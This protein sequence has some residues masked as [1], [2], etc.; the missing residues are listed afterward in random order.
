M[1]GGTTADAAGSDASTSGDAGLGSSLVFP[2]I[3]SYFIETYVGPEHEETMARADVVVI[4]V[5]ATALS[6]DALKRVRT[7]NPKADLLAYLTSEEIPHAID[8]AERPFAAERFAKIAPSEW[9]VDPGSTTTAALNATA[10]R[11]KV[12]S[13]AAFSVTRPESDFYEEDEPTY[14]LV[15]GEHMRLVEVDGNELVVERGYR[16][17]AVAH[18]TGSKIAS[19]VVFFAGTWMLNL[20]ATAPKGPA[21]TTW[22]DRLVDDA[23]GLVDKGP[24]TGVFLDVCFEDI[25]WLNGGLLDVNRDGVADD[26]KEASKQWSLGMGLAVDAAR[27]RLGPSV[28]LLANPGAQ[29]CPHPKLDGILL[30]GWPIGLPPDYLSFEA[31][32]E[33]YLQWSPLG[34]QMT[35]ANAFSPKIGFGTIEEGADE[36]A[37]TDYAAMRFGLGVALLGDGLYAFDNGVFGHY[38]TWWYDEYDGAGAGRGWLGRAKGTPKM[39]GAVR[40]REFEHGLVVVNTGTTA[41]S[42][43][44]GAAGAFDKLKGKQDPV[45]NDGAPVNGKLEVGPKDAFLLRR[46]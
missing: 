17:T 22:R 45:H 14:L 9:L 43:D 15:D 12:A 41:A 16:S 35:I 33:R 8:A 46:R 39:A 3:A 1:D 20:A 27:A 18:P 2:R 40:S 36:E 37:R 6:A 24:W 21:G 30:E 29:N 25:G 5:E 7:K 11:I 4:D 34:R 28:P 38:V 10:T 19:H 42:F 23:K 26:P 32:L 31:G 13:G 44:V